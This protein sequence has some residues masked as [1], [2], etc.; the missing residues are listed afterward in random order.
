MCDGDVIDD[1]H[2]FR[3][4][5]RTSDELSKR[6]GK[7]FDIWRHSKRFL[8]QAGFVDVTEKTFTW[9]VNGWPTEPALKTLGSMNEIR[10]VEN[11]EGYLLRLLTGTAKVRMPFGQA[12][13]FNVNQSQELIM[14]GLVDP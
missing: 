6:W 11:M 3:V 5:N 14:D 9:P 7:P 1:N 13:R 8:E 4:W 12:I 2:V 10:L